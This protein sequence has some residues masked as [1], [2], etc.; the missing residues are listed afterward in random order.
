M[1]KAVSP[2]IASVILIAVAVALAIAVAVWAGALTGSLNRPEKLIVLSSSVSNGKV[3]LSVTNLG[4]NPV[5]ISEIMFNF[6]PVPAANITGNPPLISSS[7]T[8]MIN[9]TLSGHSGVSYPL[10]VVLA[11]GGSYFADVNWP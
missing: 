5:S 7:T 9:L 4:P 6:Q 8:V 2:V 1:R 10:T 11:S 3:L